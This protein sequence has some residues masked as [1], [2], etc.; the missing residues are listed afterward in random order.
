MNLRVYIQ[1]HH[2]RDA[3]SILHAIR[4]QGE[5]VECV[6]DETDYRKLSVRQG[7][8][9][10]VYENY[11]R[12]LGHG[13]A[14][15]AEWV[16]TMQDDVSVPDGLFERIRS[17]LP[18][19]TGSIVSF[20]VPQNKLYDRAVADGVHVVESYWN[21]WIQCLAYRRSSMG[22][23]IEWG[24]RHVST[25]WAVGQ[26]E[27]D[28]GFLTKACSRL[29]IPAQTVLPSLVQHL[30]FK[31][32]LLNTSGLCGGRERRSAVYDPTFNP[33]SVDWA[34]SFAHPLVDR[35]RKLDK[36]GTFGL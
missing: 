28:D 34:Q 9:R 36:S 13:A 3:T 20:Y 14:S 18:F 6:T 10:G 17:I 11:M 19:A 21:F 26:G 30:G 35:S 12:M 2:S 27:G 31:Q 1:R 16:V 33:A 8:Y 23:I 32:S 25:A 29:R 24:H 7:R 5:H 4:R 22:P 15:D